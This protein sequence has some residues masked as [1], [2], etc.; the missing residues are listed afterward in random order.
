MHNDTMPVPQPKEKIYRLCIIGLLIIN[1]AFICFVFFYRCIQP[2]TEEIINEMVNSKQELMN[3]YEVEF[4][5]TRYILLKIDIEKDI[6]KNVQK[7][8]IYSKISQAIRELEAILDTNGIE[9][10]LGPKKKENLYKELEYMKARRLKYAG[11]QSVRHGEG[12]IHE[13]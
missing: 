1:A 2:P 10:I 4:P 11:T 3:V 12:V 9:Q 8:I 7:T 5:L 6:R 13:K